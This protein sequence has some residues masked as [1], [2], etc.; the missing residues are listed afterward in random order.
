MNSRVTAELVIRFLG[1]TYILLKKLAVTSTLNCVVI[2]GL[3]TLR[4]VQVSSAVV[5]GVTQ[6]NLSNLQGSQR[7]CY[8][9]Q[10]SAD[11]EGNTAACS[12]ATASGACTLISCFTFLLVALINALRGADYKP[13][14]RFEFVVMTLT[15]LLWIP[16]LIFLIYQMAAKTTDLDPTT[17]AGAVGDARVDG[18][19]VIVFC[20][21][22]AGLTVSVQ[23]V[24][25]S[26]LLTHLSFNLGNV[27]RTA[28]VCL[29]K[30]TIKEGQLRSAVSPA[31]DFHDQIKVC[32]LVFL[33]SLH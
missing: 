27:C 7:V 25:G 33:D 11:P 13:I 28:E 32:T 30:S 4:S 9:G 23:I 5:I 15:G 22:S 2:T 10:T 19:V 6:G 18:I 29:Y 1:C 21:L 26:P 14:H 12:L 17:H 16:T 3:V 20:A 24:F 8:Y 31:S